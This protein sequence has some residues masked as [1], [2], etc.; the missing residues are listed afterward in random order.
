MLHQ[1]LFMARN[2]PVKVVMRK[3]PGP[4]ITSLQGRPAAA[5]KT[6]RPVP[7]GQVREGALVQLE[8][9]LAILELVQLFCLCVCV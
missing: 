8:V 6:D 5:I 4:P 1:T 9:I 2:G 3:V 7:P